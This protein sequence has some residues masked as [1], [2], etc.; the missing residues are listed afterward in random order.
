MAHQA[1]PYAVSSLETLFNHLV[2]P[3]RLPGTQDANFEDLSYHFIDRLQA[4]V[5]TFD[6]LIGHVESRVRSTLEDTLLVCRDLNHGRLDRTSLAAAFGAIEKQPLILYVVAQNAGLIIRH[7]ELEDGPSVIFEAFEASPESEQV[8]AA[9]DALLC[10]FPSQ[11][12]RITLATFQGQDFQDSVA[13]F[14]EM[15]SIETFSRLAAKSRKAN[16]EVT[17]ERD[18]SNPALIT[19]MLIPFL[20]T[21]GAP[22]QTQLLRK[23][24]RDDVSL[25]RA[26]MPWR[27]HPFWLIL[28]VAVQRLLCLN[29]DD[30]KG[31]ACYKFLHAILLAQLLRDVVPKLKPDLSILLRSKLCRRL[32][33]LELERK[34]ASEEV[35]GV[36][37]NLFVSTEKWFSDIITE[38]TTSLDQVWKNVQARTTRVVPRLLHR[39][40]DKDTWLSLPSSSAH[41]ESVL[42][43]RP[44]NTAPNK[45]ID[46]LNLEDE[47][48]KRVQGFTRHYFHLAEYE[49]AME[50]LLENHEYSLSTSLETRCMDLAE[51]IKEYKAQVLNAYDTAIDQKSAYLLKLFRLW[52]E[53]DNVAVREEPLLIQYRPVFNPKLLEVLQLSN[54]TNLA[55]VQEIQLYLQR[56][57]INATRPDIFTAFNTKESFASEYLMQSPALQIHRDRIHDESTEAR[58]RKRSQWRKAHQEYQDLN[59]QKNNHTCL[60]YENGDATKNIKNCVKCYFWRQANR[61]KIKVFEEYLPE[62]REDS[63]NVVFELCVPLAFQAYRNAT[64]GLMRLAWPTQ[65]DPSKPVLALREFSQLIRFD[66]SRVSS[67]VSIASETKS[68]SQTHFKAVKIS[69][70]SVRD[71]LLPFGPRFTLYDHDSNLWVN[72]ISP[73]ALTL[74]HHCGITMPQ[75]LKKLLLSQPHPPTVMEAPSSYEVMANQNK[76]PQQASPHEFSAYQTLLF[77]PSQRWITVL[78]ELGSSNFNFSNGETARFLI[79]L[80]L[81]T[82]PS[83]EGHKL[84]DT[85]AVFADGKFCQCLAQQIEKRLLAI[86]SNFRETN[87][88]ELLITLSERLYSLSRYWTSSLAVE[89]CFGVSK[90]HETAQSAALSLIREARMATLQWITRLR[91]ELRKAK[92]AETNLRITKYGFKASILARRTFAATP[93]LLEAEDLSVY[94]QAS[95]ALQDFMV[96]EAL[97][98]DDP[99]LK[100]LL[101]RDTKMV[102]SIRHHIEA[103]VRKSYAAV[104]QAVLK[105]W[106]TST[107]DAEDENQSQT[108]FFDWEHPAA[109]WISCRIRTPTPQFEITQLLH[110]NFVEGYLLVDGKPLGRLPESIR[111]SPDVKRLFGDTYL[112]TYDCCQNGMSH[113]LANTV[114]GSQIYFGTRGNNVVIR[115]VSRHK[116]MEFIPARTFGHGGLHDLPRNLIDNCVHW[117]DL[118]ARRL[119][120]RRDPVLW[121]TRQMDWFI[122]LRLRQSRRGTQTPHRLID[123]FSPTAL[124]ISRIFK[125]FERPERIFIHQTV[126]TKGSLIVELPRFELYFR[127]N[128]CSLLEEPKL[129]M[130]I[131]T[132]QDAGTFYGLESKLVLR[133]VL[134]ETK[135]SILIPVG[136]PKQRMIGSHAE[137]VIDSGGV[138][139]YLRYDIDDTVGR[140]VCA[141]EPLLIYI[142]AYLHAVTSFPLPDPLTRRTGIEESIHVLESGMAQPW[143]PVGPPLAQLSRIA[144]LAPQREYYPKDKRRL[145]QVA[146]RN[147]LSTT[148]QHDQLAVLGQRLS[149][150]SRSL[151]PFYENAVKE[152]EVFDP[153]DHL[154]LRGIARR[155]VFEPASI[156]SSRAPQDLEYKTRDQSYTICR[157]ARKVI[158]ISRMLF[159]GNLQIPTGPSFRDILDG[160]DVGGF[161]SDTSVGL[162]KISREPVIEQLGALIECARQASTNHFFHFAIRL[163]VLAFDG[164]SDQE[165]HL[166]RN[167]VLLARSDVVKAIT[168][169]VHPSFYGFRWKHFPKVVELEQLML[170]TCPDLKYSKKSRAFTDREKYVTKFRIECHLMSQYFLQQW[171]QEEPV[172]G[173][174]A[175]PVTHLSA[176]VALA[177]VTP[178]WAKLHAN[179]EFYEYLE[180]VTKAL[181][182]YQERDDGQLQAGRA[183]CDVSK[184]DSPQQPRYFDFI[185]NTALAVPSMKDLIETSTMT[186][187]TAPDSGMSASDF[188]QESTL[189]SGFLNT[190]RSE[191]AELKSIVQYFVH[192]ADSLRQRYGNDLATSLDAMKSSNDL[193]HS[194]PIALRSS[195]STP[196]RLLQPLQL[197]QKTLEKQRDHI[198]AGFATGDRRF[199]WL[200]AANLWPG[201]D[202]V[203]LLE[204]LRSSAKIKY[205]PLV[206][207]HLVQYA[208]TVTLKQWLNRVRHA[209]IKGETTKL[210]DLLSNT[211]HENWD[212]AE[213]TDW[214]LMEIEANI[215]IRRKQIAVARQIISPES[216]ANSVLQLNMGQGKTSCIVPLAIA[217]L[218]D[219]SRLVRLICPKA[220]IFSTAQV[221]QSRI[222]GL[223]GREMRHIPYARRTPTTRDMIQVYEDLHTEI[224]ESSGLIL[225]TPDAVLSHRLSSLQRLVDGELVEASRMIQFSDRLT[226]ECRDIIDESDLTLGVKTQLVYP[227]GPRIHIDGAPQRWEVAESLLLLVAVH[228]PLVRDKFPRGLEIS[229][230]SLHAAVPS[231]GADTE[232]LSGFVMAHFLQLEA[233]D[234]LNR[235]IIEDVCHGRTHFLRPSQAMVSSNGGLEA[236]HKE[237]QFVLTEPNYDKVAPK[238]SAQFFKQLADKESAPK[239][240]LLLRGLLLSRILVTCL[241]KRWGVQYGLHPDREPIAVPFEAKGLPSDSAEFGHPDLS[242]ILTILSYLYGGVSLTQFRQALGRV[243]ASDDPAVEY[244]RLVSGST[245]LP[246]H[247]RH[248]SSINTDDAGQVEEL[249]KYLRLDS[250]VCFYYL[251]TF[252]FPAHAKAFSIKLSAS[253]WDIPLYPKVD[254]GKPSSARTTGFSGTNDNKSLL[255]LTIAQDDL[256]SLLQTNAEVLTSLLQPRNRQYELAAHMGQ[257]FTE[258]E[259][260]ARL[261]NKGIRVLI[262][263]GAYVLEMT[264][265]ALARAWLETDPQAR[266]AVF[267]DKNRASV[268]SRN[269][270]NWNKV[271]P[272]VATPW[273]ENITSDVVVFFDE[274]HCRGVDLKLPHDCKAALTLALSQTKD[275]TVQGAMRLRELATKQSVVFFGPPEVDASIRDVCNVAAANS[276]HSGHVVRWLLEMTCRNNEQLQDLH[277]AHGVDFCHRLDTQWANP[278]FVE[279]S[280]Q[281]SKL[282]DVIQAQESRTLEEQYGSSEDGVTRVSEDHVTFDCLKDFMHQLEDQ[283][284]NIEDRLNGRGM[285]NAALEEVER[286]RQVEHQVEE[287]RQV[288]KPVTY[289][290]LPFPGLSPV[291][292]AFAKS[293]ELNGAED[294]LHV[295]D[296][297]RGTAIGSKFKVRGTGS[298]LYCSVEFSRAVRVTKAVKTTD[299]FMRPV[300]W[301]LWNPTNETAMIIIPEEAELLIRQIRLSGSF[302]PVHLVAFSTPVTKTMKHFDDLKFYTIPA[303]PLDY[304]FPTWFRLELGFFAGRLYVP[305]DECAAVADYLGIPWQSSEKSQTS[306]CAFTS[307]PIAF[308]QEWLALRRQVQDITQTPM[309][310]ILSGRPLAKDHP[311]FATTSLAVGWG[312]NSLTTANNS[313]TVSQD[314]EDDEDEDGFWS[315]EETATA[316]IGEGDEQGEDSRLEE[317]NGSYGLTG[318]GGMD[319]HKDYFM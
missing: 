232:I 148:T 266:A 195:F 192:S 265:Q 302:S 120:I 290:P 283:Q 250:H 90:E 75:V 182:G 109:N 299:D 92:D 147:D 7:E 27:R 218:A 249:H 193:Q 135:R 41:L 171:P 102:W 187:V 256:P 273:A 69:R 123:P 9:R 133:D 49:E 46:P 35:S 2:L 6:G 234:E 93:S 291:L 247:Y 106:G 88:M 44:I 50:S 298:Q 142:K 208:I 262:D 170:S 125:S 270:A 94:C 82:G 33:K 217:I 85:F 186:K 296:S 180:R 152:D 242:I 23:R 118:Y 58:E 77:G 114:D 53:L 268:L 293:G 154:R 89:E 159:D 267:F 214:L 20:E 287:V 113:R 158:E 174:T 185:S 305:F 116:T 91:A 203:T 12:T 100:A 301:I 4:S 173:D 206:K 103:S 34:A 57:I 245:T 19:Q 40:P 294:Y 81:Q 286:E 146:F 169:P 51:R 143:R 297:L 3:P 295:F 251:N 304:E 86:S 317:H 177:A 310:Y 261:K 21:I 189:P 83:T 246:E 316:V 131:D 277:I 229:R 231:A 72:A 60:C 241:K 22:Y 281:R 80:A 42:Q 211:G 271:V 111:Q 137:V 188:I 99:D 141:P 191:W 288:A 226:E 257:R 39:A 144:S 307:N 248:A 36:Y 73:D 55:K 278:G 227:S 167:L 312:G 272:L 97:L 166:L 215:L 219:Q 48:I 110:F 282:F 309:G 221:I 210:T 45:S 313:S 230:L 194:G 64:F 165:L 26:S 79:E 13:D 61:L 224:R 29:L 269:G 162:D 65:P 10:T 104:H 78:A 136:E 308:L 239:V 204:Q 235:L 318:P 157:H 161:P 207:E 280:H 181:E 258:L 223:V 156:H 274:A 238:L 18:T 190:T 5:A 138:E 160:Q 115:T 263:T 276:I 151:D 155:R 233:E 87:A 67:G 129:K 216:Q 139:S 32:A 84:R 260:L 122:D 201:R 14:L 117:L 199:P 24:V 228:L 145:Q 264:N 168:T 70:S 38:A 306:G 127:V 121:R 112:L 284:K 62:A 279:D 47:G 236:F 163:A 25:E 240:I 30:R 237:L 179:W 150:K 225:T 63:A 76:C 95:I 222:G 98:D 28:R 16:T 285:H 275:H 311:F 209:M 128:Q 149:N 197:I 244:D 198:M 66:K 140:L 196:Y 259:L 52:M 153:P 119:D 68:F 213:Q 17:E 130:V 303:L 124:Q 8:L 164:P 126:S 200:Q 183:Q 11:A 314:E 101:L 56:R 43:H 205:G 31:R 254:L 289:K 96:T 292:K 178:T 54:V 1:S 107:E 212:P 15:A 252:V 300:R 108:E 132:S 255:P 71:V 59:F 202:T 220:L 175:P 243:L 37:N 319:G 184:I 105:G 134:N 74:Q 172:L 253:S 176:E 315:S